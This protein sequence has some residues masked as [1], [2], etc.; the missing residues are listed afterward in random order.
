V[1]RIVGHILRIVDTAKKLVCLAI[2]GVCGEY[3]VKA[4]SRFI[5]PTLLEES[6]GLGRVG[7]EKA[8]AEKQEKREGNVDTGRRSRSEHD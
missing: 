6:I 4:G 1:D 5:D 2:A 7:Q 8:S 3:L